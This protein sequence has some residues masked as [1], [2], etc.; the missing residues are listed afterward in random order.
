MDGREG[1]EVEERRWRAGGVMWR[2]GG[3]GLVEGCGVE[4]VEERRWRM[5]VQEVP[6]P[7]TGSCFWEKP[8]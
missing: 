1:E 3:G 4:D 8:G 5:H 7:L 6:S 2:R